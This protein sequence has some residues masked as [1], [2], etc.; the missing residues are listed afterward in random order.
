MMRR[1]CS[2]EDYIV[3]N[4]YR[5]CIA[6]IDDTK[7]L[8][9]SWKF[10]VDYTVLVD[11]NTLFLDWAKYEDMR[12]NV[13]FDFEDASAFSQWLDMYRNFKIDWV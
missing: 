6:P 10:I 3:K 1:F 12:Y 5:K 4:F 8:E 11:E 9:T 2:S 7:L 13:K